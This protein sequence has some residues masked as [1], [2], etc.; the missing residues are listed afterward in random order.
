MRP[1]K[2]EG[3]AS[4]QGIVVDKSLGGA[5]CGFRLDVNNGLSSKGMHGRDVCWLRAA[6][7]Y[8]PDAWTHVVAV[9]D[10]NGVRKL[11]INGKLAGELKRQ[12][13]V[14]IE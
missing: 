2:G 11:Y 3:L 1:K 6:C 14:V 7:R 12:V 4:S 5:P 9:F 13:K 8:P 10:V